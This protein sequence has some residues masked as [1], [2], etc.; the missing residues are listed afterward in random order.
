MSASDATMPPKCPFGKGLPQPPA[1]LPFF[2]FLDHLKAHPAVGSPDE[3]DRIKQFAKEVLGA[4]HTC[5]DFMEMRPTESLLTE[6]FNKASVGSAG[7]LL[8]FKNALGHLNDKWHIE[9]PKPQTLDE[10]TRDNRIR[11][12]H[13]KK[14]C[15]DRPG[16]GTELGD[17]LIELKP[18]SGAAWDALLV[19]R[20]LP[21]KGTCTLSEPDAGALGKFMKKRI[22]LAPMVR[23]N[24][25]VD[26]A[27]MCPLPLSPK[28]LPHS[29]NELKNVP[30]G[31][32]SPVTPR[33]SV[34][35]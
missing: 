13:E 30:A 18:A 23:G 2:E 29:L 21:A 20:H 11:L 22:C 27:L 31:S 32:R 4:F 17:R 35:T 15:R 9:D 7:W 1:E 10:D 19:V 25:Y 28:N 26:E 24:S 16:I 33:S 5:E 34:S 14:S 8:M 3:L 6:L 12:Y